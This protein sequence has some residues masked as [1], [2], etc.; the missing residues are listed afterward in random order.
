M[1]LDEYI[2]KEADEKHKQDQFISTA[3]VLYAEDQ[4]SELSDQIIAKFLTSRQGHTGVT[5]F[6]YYRKDWKL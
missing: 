5:Y 1:E 3:R 2:F 4:I 6:T